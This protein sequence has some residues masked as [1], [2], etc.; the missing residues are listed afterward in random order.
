M[1]RSGAT[2]MTSTGDTNVIEALHAVFGSLRAEYLNDDIYEM[3]TQPAYWPVLLTVQPCM[4]VGGRGTGKTTV[5]RSLSFQGQSR[6]NGSDPAKWPFV[7]VYWRVDT[8]VVTAFRGGSLGEE[9]WGML[10]GHYLN[11]VFVSRILEFCEWY[12]NDSGAAILAETGASKVATALNLAPVA[13]LDELMSSIDGALI[14]FEGFVNNAATADVPLLSMGG[15]PVELLV[16]ELQA[17][18][19]FGEVAFCLL[20]DEFENLENYQQ[21]ILNTLIKHSSTALSYKIGMKTAGHRERATLNPNEQLME[22]ADYALIDISPSLIDNG[23]SAF[24]EKICNDRLSRL[25]RNLGMKEAPTI[26]ALLPRLTEREEATLLGVEREVRS[27]RAQ[28]IGQ[29]VEERDLEFWDG[30]P[31]LDQAL[32]SFW[33][34]AQ[35]LPLAS[36]LADRRQHP[37]EWAGRR[38]NYQYAMLFT[39]R[40]GKRGI[41]KFYCGWDTF[42][43]LAHGNIRFLLFLVNA[44]LQRH[45]QRNGGA[46]GDPVP[47]AEQT[48]AAQEVGKRI[49]H[50]LQGLAAEG[51]QLTRLVLGLGRIFGV[52][53]AQPHKHAP[54]VNQFRVGWN[55]HDPPTTAAATALLAAAVMHLAVVRFPGDKAAR[56]SGETKDYDYSLHPVFAPFFVYSHRSKRRITVPVEDIL[57]LTIDY[58]QAIRSV[59]VKND[60]RPDLDLPEQLELLGFYE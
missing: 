6:L 41:R 32:V 56:A 1:A 23:F 12:S 50:E 21:K 51:A 15:R 46:L 47:P 57:A 34:K 14:Q 13:G 2:P 22:P 26:K 31:V 38:N 48:Y 36:Q 58:N 20:I 39:L 42:V 35:Q 43:G 45:H 7:G 33:A 11:L 40:Q 49:V 28:L 53:A 55:R 44:S 4:L 24:A 59:L 8:N 9:R 17:D 3:F 30:L 10:F 27:A 5:L 54:E 18:P 19:R 16:R 52:M 29:G 25:A 60:R 37:Q